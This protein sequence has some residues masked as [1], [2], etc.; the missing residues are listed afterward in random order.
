[1]ARRR[2][3]LES[4]HSQQTCA[5]G[6]QTGSDQP[7]HR[8][9]PALAIG[10]PHAT[11]CPST[12][13]RAQPPLSPAPVSVRSA[14]GARSNG[15]IF[16]APREFPACAPRRCAELF[17]STFLLSDMAPDPPKNLHLSFIE[18]HTRKQTAQSGHCLTGVIPVQKPTV[19]EGL[20][21]VIQHP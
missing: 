10:K 6:W 9:W 7:K 2:P 19:D 15:R 3:L 18:F 17:C 14:H 11:G 8:P 13:P 21:Q 5:F 12:T 20:V 16:S 4:T 1:M